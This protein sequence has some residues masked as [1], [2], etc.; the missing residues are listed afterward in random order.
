MG[1]LNSSVRRLNS[2]LLSYCIASQTKRENV[3]NTLKFPLHE[4]N[5][6]ES[7]MEFLNEKI[8]DLMPALSFSELDRNDRVV[9]SGVSINSV[10]ILENGTI[11]I[12][13]EYEW[14][15][16]A[17]CRDIDKSG[18]KCESVQARIVG[19]VIVFDINQPPEARSPLDEL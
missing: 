1:R 8:D 5:I 12:Y 11:E 19:G 3:L 2:Q 10:H 13:Y 17:G 9:I 14:S 7:L 18:L 6:S 16:F 4:T 15:F